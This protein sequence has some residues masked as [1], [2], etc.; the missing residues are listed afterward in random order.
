M[1][2]SNQPVA[3]VN[4]AFVPENEA[5][6][7]IFDRGLRFADTVFDTARTIAHRPYKLTE[8]LE[9]LRHS[10]AYAR[11]DAG[12]SM[13][14]LERIT[15]EVVAHNTGFLASHDDVWVRQ[16]VTRGSVSRVGAAEHATPSVIVTTERLP[17]PA[18][19]RGYCLGVPMLVPSVRALPVASID[20]RMKTASRMTNNLAEHEVAAIDAEASPL[21]LDIDGFV[22][23]STGANFF[24]VI[25]GEL[26]T[27]GDLAVLNGISRDT[28]I[29]LAHARAIP[30]R[31]ARMTMFDVHNADEAFLTGTSFCIEPVRSVNGAVFSAG[32]PGPITRALTK[33]WA[34]S[35]DHDFVA[36]ALSH[37]EPGEREKLTLSEERKAGVIR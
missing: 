17:F 26:V 29:A 25:D 18:M 36:Q 6:L 15:I 14:E 21:L 23:E 7:S 12:L 34:E 27:P 22:S 32:T 9:R 11:M 13:D 24:A 16:Y 5:T 1:L 19:A 31:T 37:L 2:E 28:V 20:P 4:G 8:H 3:Y 10:L 30:C 35:I 33:A